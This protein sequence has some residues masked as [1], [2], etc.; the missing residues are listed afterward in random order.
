MTK[1]SNCG[2]FNQCKENIRAAGK[3]KGEGAGMRKEDMPPG[4]GV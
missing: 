4:H 3:K 1:R 2:H